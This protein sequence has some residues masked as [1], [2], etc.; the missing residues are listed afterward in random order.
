VKLLLEVEIT[1]DFEERLKNDSIIDILNAVI[2]EGAESVAL[3]G[4]YKIIEVYDN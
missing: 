1:G 3:N 4:R 2:V